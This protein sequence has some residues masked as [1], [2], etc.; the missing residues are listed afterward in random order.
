MQVKIIPAPVAPSPED[1]VQITLSRTEA[2]VLQSLLGKCYMKA[3]LAGT[4][5]LSALH[6][7]LYSL[8]IR[9]YSSG[10]RSAGVQTTSF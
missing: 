7:K 9:D 8:G 3:G 5:E 10:L 2:A 1:E 4:E 6:S